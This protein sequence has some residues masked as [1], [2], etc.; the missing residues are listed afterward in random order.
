MGQ[1]RKNIE[2]LGAGT[3]E[4]RQQEL[5]RTLGLGTN[6][7][8][9]WGKVHEATRQAYLHPAVDEPIRN[10]TDTEIERSYI[11]V[12][13]V[14]LSKCISSTRKRPNIRRHAHASVQDSVTGG[15][16][17][18]NTAVCSGCLRRFIMVHARRQNS[19]LYGG[20]LHDGISCFPPSFFRG[21]WSRKAQLLVC[22]K[23]PKWCCVHSCCHA[24]K[25]MERRYIQLH[26]YIV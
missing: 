19:S 15:S 12:I 6:Y 3:L 26:A 20:N 1:T 18:W 25:V 24:Q 10:S 4:G 13:N 23:I 7:C 22:E 2:P 14:K 17:W 11:V 9:Q 8:E 16:V 5:R 21:K